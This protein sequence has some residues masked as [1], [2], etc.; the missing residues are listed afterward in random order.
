MSIKDTAIVLTLLAAGFGI[1]TLMCRP[2]RAPTARIEHRERWELDPQGQAE[3]LSAE[4]CRA[5]GRIPY[6][7]YPDNV[8]PFYEE[9]LR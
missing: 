4:Q 1:G 2:P 9:C 5:A 6:Y 7:I 8:T 3:N